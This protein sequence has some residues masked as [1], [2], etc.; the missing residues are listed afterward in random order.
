MSRDQINE[1]ILDYLQKFW[2]M[3]DFPSHHCSLYDRTGLHT[4]NP[5]TSL[6]RRYARNLIMILVYYRDGI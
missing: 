1:L 6:M 3:V 5:R 4:R 2:Q